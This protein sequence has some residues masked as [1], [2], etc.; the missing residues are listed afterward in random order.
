MCNIVIFRG[1]DAYIEVNVMEKSSSEGDIKLI[2]RKLAFSKSD[3]HL[4]YI[5]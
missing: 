2:Q 1:G 3:I 4:I 5:A